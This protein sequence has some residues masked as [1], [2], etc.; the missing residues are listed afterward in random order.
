[1]QQTKRYVMR[2]YVLYVLITM[3][4]LWTCMEMRPLLKLC[5]LKWL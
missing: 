3:R 1:M 4:L 5:L 2:K